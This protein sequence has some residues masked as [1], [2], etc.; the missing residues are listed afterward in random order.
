MNSA[1][2]RTISGV[3]KRNQ[4]F[5]FLVDSVT[6]LYVAINIFMGYV[7]CHFREFI[8]GKPGS[9]TNFHPSQFR[10]IMNIVETG[11]GHYTGVR[12]EKQ[13]SVTKISNTNKLT[14]ASLSS[15]A[16]ERLKEW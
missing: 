13:G 8:N 14:S 11:Q 16:I 15:Q 3:D 6:H 10:A 1:T 4:E 12:I 2:K 7:Q 5:R 9:G